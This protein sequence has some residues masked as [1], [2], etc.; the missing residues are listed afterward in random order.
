[1]DESAFERGIDA[2][3][4]QIARYRLT[5]FAAVERIPVLAECDPRV[6]RQMLREA[7]RRRLIA[8]VPLHATMRYWHLLPSGAESAGVNPECSGPLSEPA[9]LRA[10]ALLQ[11]CRLGDVHRERLT[12]QELGGYLAESA[13]PGLPGTY[14]FDAAVSR[15]GLARL[16][17]G[18]RGRWDRMVQSVQADVTRH[19]KHSGFRRLIEAGRFEIT[20]LTVLRAKALRLQAAFSTVSDQRRLPLNV[21]ALPELLPL[22][23]SCR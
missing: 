14:Y 16:D 4:A 13:R 18:R 19:L 9:K 22:V 1:M 6:A 7:E 12:T 5:V 21:V 17:V 23:T 10:L 8:D 15:I 3:L 20:V 11:F 2:I